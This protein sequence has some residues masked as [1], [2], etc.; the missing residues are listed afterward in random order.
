[1]SEGS[2][3]SQRDYGMAFKLG[4]VGA[5]EKGEMTYKQAQRKYGIQGRSTVLVWLRKYGQLD[6][7]QLA[8]SMQQRRRNQTIRDMSTPLTPEQRIKQLEAELDRSQKQSLVYRTMLDVI[9]KEHGV[10]LVKKHSP[11][12]LKSSKKDKA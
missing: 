11:G 10:N 2:R 9:A 5:V 6:W 8:G 3:R 12:Q 7:S 1:M 4:V